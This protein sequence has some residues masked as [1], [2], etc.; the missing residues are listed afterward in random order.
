MGL[1]R[2]LPQPPFLSY[3]HISH[4]NSGVL[5]NFK[6]PLGFRMAAALDAMIASTNSTSWCANLLYIGKKLS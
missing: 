5:F 2:S 1:K 6:T 3:I 4:Q